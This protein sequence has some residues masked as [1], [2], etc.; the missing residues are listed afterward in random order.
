MESLRI[1][2]W[3]IVIAVALVL[4]YIVGVIL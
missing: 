1:P 2:R 4:N 3:A